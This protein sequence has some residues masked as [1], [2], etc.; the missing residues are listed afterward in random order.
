MRVV[1]VR[2]VFV[3][4]YYY[5]FGD[6]AIRCG[7]DRI[8]CVRSANAPTASSSVD[9]RQCW[10]TPSI[11]WTSGSW[12]VFTGE[13]TRHRRRGVLIGNSANPATH[14]THPSRR[15]AVAEYRYCWPI[16]KMW[17]A[18]LTYFSLFWWASTL[19]SQDI[20]YCTNESN[21]IFFFADFSIST[22]TG[23]RFFFFF[24]KMKT[25]LT[26]LSIEMPDG[27]LKKFGYRLAFFHFTFVAVL[28][29]YSFLPVKNFVFIP[30]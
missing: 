7:A 8:F 9:T 4:R 12:Y 21:F 5:S 6:R 16:V 1:P 10:W 28:I 25:D 19:L 14:L 30:S 20:Q 11:V 2:C 17:F 3:I 27:R 18:Q 26:D 29:R 15:S 22:T 13:R 24:F 23:N